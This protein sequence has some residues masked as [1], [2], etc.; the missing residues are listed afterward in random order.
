[1]LKRII[2]MLLA[3]ACLLTAAA[4][5]SEDED[6]TRIEGTLKNKIKLKKNYPD[7]PVIE[8]VSSTTGLPASGE[9]FTPIMVVID[10]TPDCNPH[11]GLDQA[12][13]I[14]QVPNAGVGATKYLALFADH[15][16]ELAGS[17]RSGRASMVPVA[18]AWDAAFVYGG[19][20]AAQGNNVNI[21]TLMRKFKM[22]ADGQ[23]LKNYNLL[24]SYGHREDFLPM[25]HNLSARVADIHENCM[26]EGVSF[27]QRP[28]RFTDEPRTAGATAEYIKVVH[29]GDTL[30]KPVNAS[31]T[32][33]FYYDAARGGYTRVH[34]E[35]DDVDRFTGNQMVYSNVI[36]MRIKFNWQSNYV[37]FKDHMVGSG[38][39]EI[40][41]NG[42]YVR[43]AWFRKDQDSRLVFID[44]NGEELE[45]QR[46]KSFIIITNDASGVSY[47]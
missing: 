4:A 9:V 40:F 3:L 5:L 39:A 33:F 21:K 17:V 6:V 27:E 46:G 11:W 20:S 15:Y 24:G 22:S 1:M 31:S 29:R 37:Y 8:G 7:N 34:K 32:N 41:Q 2:A 44:E 36:V 13:I 43:G 14:F 26:A 10:G 12:D 45:F 38:P 42:H 23:K 35:Y 28:F 18:K 16:P 25:P 30:S 47:R 19:P